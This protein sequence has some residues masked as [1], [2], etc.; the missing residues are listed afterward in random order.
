MNIEFRRVKDIDYDILRKIVAVEKE[1]FKEDG[2]TIASLIPFLN[3]QY[4]F[5]GLLNDEVAC[6]AQVMI[7][8]D[9][10]NELAFLFGLAVNYKYR[11][12]KVG[13]KF[14]SFIEKELKKKKIKKFRLYVDP[15]RAIDFYRKCNYKDIS[16][17]PDFYLEGHDRVLMEK[18]L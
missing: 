17:H 16:F 11:N 8:V 4:L 13:T 12:Q 9:S 7:D 3:F 2:L 5:V 1:A 10:N 6:E 18:E 14:L 15:K